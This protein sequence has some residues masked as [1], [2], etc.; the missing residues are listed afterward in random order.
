MIE[1]KEFNDIRK[2]VVKTTARLFSSKVYE[3]W[4]DSFAREESNKTMDALVKFLKTK[5]LT[6]ASK[7]QLRDLGCQAWDE[8]S[9][10]LLVPL[11]IA[12]SL[13]KDTEVMGI[14][15]EVEKH[16][17]DRFDDDIRFGCC[18]FGLV[19]S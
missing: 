4:N 14:G 18:A 7:Q 5:D 1:E 3:N 15:G 13:P 19:P 6:K 8:D 11:Y 12:L 10:V 16:D 2:A 17:P 9:P